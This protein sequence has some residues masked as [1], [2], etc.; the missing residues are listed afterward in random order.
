MMQG[1]PQDSRSEFLCL[2]DSASQSA[3]GTTRDFDV[4]ITAAE[5]SDRLLPNTSSIRSRRI[6]VLEAGPFA[7]PEH[8]QNM[9]FM[10]GAL[11]MRL[12]WANHPALNCAGLL[13]AV[14]GRSLTWGGWS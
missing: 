13:F 1:R 14:G 11:D 10:G 4:I 8:A 12:P 3:A 7:L 6:L 2:R 5:R 9:P